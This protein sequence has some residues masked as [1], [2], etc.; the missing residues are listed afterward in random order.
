MRFAAGPG[1]VNP[2]CARGLQS[3]ERGQP[4]FHVKRRGTYALARGTSWPCKHH[5]HKRSELV[6]RSG[7]SHK[8]PELE[9][10]RGTDCTELPRMRDSQCYQVPD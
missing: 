10:A 4:A 5:W 7:R 1:A 3:S 8:Q 9:T 2:P 6:I